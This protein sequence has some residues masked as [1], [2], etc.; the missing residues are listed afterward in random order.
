M[1]QPNA[2]IPFKVSY[3]TSLKSLNDLVA[4]RLQNAGHKPVPGSNVQIKKIN[5]ILEIKFLNPQRNIPEAVKVS[6][7]KDQ[8]KNLKFKL[9]P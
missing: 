3:V 8:I 5:Y 1:I 2:Q 4:E 6:F 7:V 9:N